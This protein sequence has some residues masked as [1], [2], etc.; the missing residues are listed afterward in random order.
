MR[1]M[2]HRTAKGAWRLPALLL[3]LLLVA[4]GCGGDDG[5][6]PSAASP[7][8]GGETGTPGDDPGEPT[9]TT[10][11]TDASGEPILLGATLPLTGPVAGPAEN[12]RNGYQ[13]AIDEINAAGGVCEGQPLELLIEDDAFDPTQAKQLTEKLITSDGVV[14]MLGTY[15]SGVALTASAEAERH[16]V[17]N[18]QAFASAPEI[19]DRGF[20][21]L[22]N[23]F[24]MSTQAEAAFDEFMQTVVEP[25]V[26]SVAILYVD[27]P[28][29][30]PGAEESRERLE[31]AGIEVPLFERFAFD[32]SD[33][34]GLV[35]QARQAEV[36]VIKHLG[37][38]PHHIA[39]M[40]ALQQQN[41]A[42]TVVY[43]ETQYAFARP[44]L[45]QLG[46]SANWVLGNPNWYPGLTPEFEEK[47]EAEFGSPTDT[48]GAWGYA[49][50]EMMRQA[51]EDADCG[52]SQ[53]IRDALAD[54]EFETIVGNISFNE[55]GQN[56]APTQ[57]AQLQDGEVVILW[58]ESDAT[59][60]WQPFPAWDNRG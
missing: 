34:S 24:R 37:Y 10:E 42:P 52:D 60:E 33:F 31:A 53:A 51:L 9:P 48:E 11:P 41:V 22:F 50:V 44:V 46:D 30:I 58:P 29:A 40:Q 12:L 57:I 39:L 23:T 21:Y 54:G 17:P 36:D 19:I 35:A 1:E 47:Y 15:G 6:E 2:Q 14:A 45:E 55:Q 32:T 26:S 16:Q 28:F 25:A 5:S 7:T 27:N 13:M 8:A 59:G 38:Q 4:S 56:E 20:E 43:T 49:V 18:I 3:A